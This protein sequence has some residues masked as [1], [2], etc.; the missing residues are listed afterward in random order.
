MKKFNVVAASAVALSAALA[1]GSALAHGTL[2]VTVANYNAASVAA[3]GGVITVPWGNGPSAVYTVTALST[4]TGLVTTSL[5]V[6]SRFTVTLP[7]GFS[8]AS[9]PSL[10]TG[11]AITSTAL[12]AGGIGSQTATFQIGAPAVAG[13]NSPLPQGA[14]LALNTV[15]VQGATALETP[16]TIG[17]QITE[18]ATNNAEI[19]NNDAAPVFPTAPGVTFTSDTGVTP[20]FPFNFPR[21]QVDLTPPSLGTEFFIDPPVSIDAP[22]DILGTFLLTGTGSLAANGSA[23]IIS[24]TDTATVTVA[25]FFNGIKESFTTVGAGNTLGP[26]ATPVTTGTAT[27]TSITVTAEGIVA[28]GPGAD[29]DLLANGTT[30][31]QANNTNFILTYAPGVGTTDFLGGTVPSTGDSNPYTGGCSISVTNFLTGDDAGYTSLVRFSNDSLSTETLFAVAE[32]YTGG[33]TLVGELGTVGAGI[34]T[35]FTETQI[36]I[37]TG[38]TL[39]NSG[40]RATLTLIAIP[41]G[42]CGSTVTASGLLVNPGGVVDNVN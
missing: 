31:L 39:A 22:V 1:S 40:Q 36:G 35:I 37:A 9:S 4:P 3:A 27:A 21:Y 15:S 7:A 20:S 5:E 18:Q 33:P 17:L 16:T 32:P 34:G 13:G 8:F 24:T 6:N 14:T 19:D 12:I 10:T 23:A 30:L 25:G 29:I 26:F 28:P 11:G 38:L 2:A 41:G 42:A